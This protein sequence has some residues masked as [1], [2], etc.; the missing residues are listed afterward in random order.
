MSNAKIFT[1]RKIE[2]AA[3]LAFNIYAAQSELKWAK[4]AWELLIEEGLATY[5]NS[6]TCEAQSSFLSSAM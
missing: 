3:K 4:Q 6:H 1:W 2:S 5:S